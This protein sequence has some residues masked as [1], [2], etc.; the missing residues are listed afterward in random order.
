MCGRYAQSLNT[1][2]LAEEFGIGVQTPAEELPMSWNIA[3]T[4][5]IY[6]VRAS[7]TIAEQKELSIASWGIMAHWHQ[8]EAEARASQSHAINA[9]SE[10]IHEKPTFRH[11]FRTSRCL[12]PATGYYEWATSLGKYAP[13]QPFYISRLDKGQ[14]SIAGIWSSWQSEK[15]QV[16]QSAAIITR[17][18]VGELATIHSRMPVFMPEER[19][20]D[21][22][23]PEG[24]DINR[25]I[26]LM[27]NADPAAGVAPVPVSSRVNVVANNGPELI[28]PIELGAPETLF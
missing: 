9:R 18:A 16:I 8:S 11:A 15:G 12:I 24:R 19:W 26:K 20:S 7:Q 17:E 13:K 22:L 23:D 28:A 21:W 2:E 4:N 6:I 5:P 25:L 14:L 1:S 10:S 27:V 3:P